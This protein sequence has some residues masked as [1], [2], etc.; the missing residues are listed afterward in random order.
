MLENY[1]LNKETYCTTNFYNRHPVVHHSF[2]NMVLM[3]LN[4]NDCID[5]LIT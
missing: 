2:H 3:P 1:H 5:N 4:L